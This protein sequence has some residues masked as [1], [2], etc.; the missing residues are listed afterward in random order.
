MGGGELEMKLISDFVKID[1][2]NEVITIYGINYSADLFRKFGI[3]TIDGELF[4]ILDRGD[5][6]IT[7]KSHRNE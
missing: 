3:E 6:V 2:D 7:I 4:E 5:G 1:E